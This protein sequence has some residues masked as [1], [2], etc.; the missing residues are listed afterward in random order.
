[1]NFDFFSSFSEDF[2]REVPQVHA[3]VSLLLGHRSRARCTTGPPQGPRPSS[4]PLR[5]AAA[6]GLVSSVWKP[7]FWARFFLLSCFWWEDEVSPCH[8]IPTKSDMSGCHIFMNIIFLVVMIITY[9]FVYFSLN[10]VVAFFMFYTL[11]IKSVV[12]LRFWK[13][14]SGG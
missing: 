11:L 13:V 4:R 1:M 14:W 9:N 7:S 6:C 10:N 8:S 12:V 2:P 5:A 3:G